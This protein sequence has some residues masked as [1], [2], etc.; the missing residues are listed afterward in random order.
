M[1]TISK[2]K[3]RNLP[4]SPCVLMKPRTSNK[5]VQHAIFF[6]EITTDFQIEKNLLLLKSMNGTTCGEDLLQNLAEDNKI[7]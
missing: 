2:K 5:T 7:A 3:P 6:R 1:M 4:I